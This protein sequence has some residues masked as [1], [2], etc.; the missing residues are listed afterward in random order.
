MPGLLN[1]FIQ[2]LGNTYVEISPPTVLNEGN[3]SASAL[4]LPV[5]AAAQAYDLLVA[6]IFTRGNKFNA[7]AGWFLATEYAFGVTANPNGIT[8]QIFYTLLTGANPGNVSFPRSVSATATNQGLIEA[9]RRDNARRV[10]LVAAGT[11]ENLTATNNFVGN[12]L[13]V[14]ASQTLVIGAVG[15]GTGV[16]K[17]DFV[18]GDFAVAN[19]TN[20]ANAATQPAAPP[21]ETVPTDRWLG[22]F[23]ARSAVANAFSCGYARH[24]PGNLASTG[25]VSVTAPGGASQGA[26]ALA[27]FQLTK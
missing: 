8:T 25:A 13:T 19:L 5:P 18:L 15:L 23:F 12:S 20:A 22:S 4:S 10:T 2:R 9:Y 1:P 11:T 26:V 21:P 27:V 7:P 14:N 24:V 3:G 16:G 17:T 6:R